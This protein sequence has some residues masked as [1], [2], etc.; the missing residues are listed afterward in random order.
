MNVIDLSKPQE[1]VLIKKGELAQR[2]PTTAPTVEYTVPLAT[3]TVIPIGGIK[4]VNRSNQARKFTI[5]KDDDGSGQADVN[6]IRP[7]KDIP[8]NDYWTNE[9]PIFMDTVGGTISTEGETNNIFT[10][11][12]F[13]QI[14][15]NK[16]VRNRINQQKSSW[17][18]FFPID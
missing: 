9:Y 12:V 18:I 2:E 4:V 14:K 7:P 8:S 15:I 17:S 16:P 13:K 5:W 11:I 1:F 10:Y 6:L 3:R